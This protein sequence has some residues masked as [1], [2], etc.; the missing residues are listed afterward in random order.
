MTRVD[1]SY[2]PTTV[3]L[4]GLASKLGV[5]TGYL[6][7]L[8]QQRPDLFDANVNG[9]LRG[10]G[11]QREV[12]EHHGVGPLPSRLPD[13]GP[14]ERKFLI[15]AFKGNGEGVARAFLSDKFKPIDNFDV[16]GNALRYRSAEPDGH[17]VANQSAYVG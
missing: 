6:K 11:W 10:G 15:R 2:R 1:G 17:G 4:E 3:A 14:D 16:L 5:P 12:L 7:T 8:H 13:Y 9:W